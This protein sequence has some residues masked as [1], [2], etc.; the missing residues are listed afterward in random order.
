M[1]VRKRLAQNLYHTVADKI[2]TW[3]PKIG[4]RNYEIPHAAA[5]GENRGLHEAI[6]QHFRKMIHVT[7]GWSSSFR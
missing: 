6:S 3:V 5:L 1:L 4:A 2:I 7:H